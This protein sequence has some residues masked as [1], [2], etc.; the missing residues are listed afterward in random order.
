MA[1]RFVPCLLS[2]TCTRVRFGLQPPMSPPRVET[3]SRTTPPTRAVPSSLSSRSAPTIPPATEGYQPLAKRVLR[4]RLAQHI[5][6]YSFTFAL[7]LTV[8]GRLWIAG[9]GSALAP[10]TLLWAALR[11]AGGAWPI[12]T[13]RK[14]YL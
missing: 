5:F 12:I 7:G 3:W 10:Q 9:L 6:P 13:M 4:D 11:W 2:S 14:A 8:L 1:V